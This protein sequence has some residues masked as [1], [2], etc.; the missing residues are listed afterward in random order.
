[1]QVHDFSP[2]TLPNGLFWVAQLPQNAFKV[3]DGGRRARLRLRAQPLVDTFTL[4]GPLAI[5]AQVD[6]EVTWVATGEAMAR[7]KGA[8]VQPTSPAAFSGDF[9]EARCR[10]KVRGVEIGFAFATGTLTATD[11]FA[12]IGPERNGIFLD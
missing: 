3:R 11:F 6:L 7:G 4:G 1:M 10:G 12:E 2:G 9:A 8:A 5:A